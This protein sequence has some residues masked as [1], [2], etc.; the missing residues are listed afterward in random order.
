MKI[1]YILLFSVFCFS[2]CPPKE[3]IVKYTRPG[4]YIFVED[5]TTRSYRKYIVESK[6]SVNSIFSEYFKTEL[7]LVDVQTPITIFNG[8]I[9]F[10]IARVTVFEKPNGKLNFRH[11]KYPS[12]TKLSYSRIIKRSKMKPA[13]F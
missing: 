7:E 8:C 5:L 4:Y 3:K 2:F 9:S 12:L 11:L 13:I 6:D 10:Y 1:L